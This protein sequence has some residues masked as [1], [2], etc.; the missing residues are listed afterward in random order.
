M[1]ARSP[2]LEDPNYDLKSNDS[3]NVL[4]WRRLNLRDFPQIMYEI[5]PYAQDFPSIY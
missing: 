1:R 3:R 5:V 4:S 2:L